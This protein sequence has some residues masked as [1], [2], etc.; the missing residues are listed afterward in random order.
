M[1]T[2]FAYQVTPKRGKPYLVFHGS[3]AHD[4]AK[5]FGYNLKPLY[6]NL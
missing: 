3:V 6:E 4:N 5:L 1:P 2:P